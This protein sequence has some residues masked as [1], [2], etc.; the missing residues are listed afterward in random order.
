MRYTIAQLKKNQHQDAHFEDTLDLSIFL[1]EDTDFLGISPVQVEGHYTIEDDF[2]YHF[3]MHIKA[4]LTIAC[5]ITLEPVSVPLDFNV[6]ET[7]STDIKDEYHQVEGI[8]I[9]LLPIIWSNIYLE[10]PLRVVAKNAKYNN[11]NQE[12]KSRVNPSFKDLDKFKR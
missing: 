4:E 6:V 2:Y 7:F 12:K 1:E 8:T 5:A 11:P 9:D 3:H 10:K